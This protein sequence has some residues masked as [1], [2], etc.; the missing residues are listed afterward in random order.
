[1]NM[2]FVDLESMEYVQDKNI[3]ILIQRLDNNTRV[4]YFYL[5]VGLYVMALMLWVTKF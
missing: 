1:M 3:S 4:F 5:S 2:C